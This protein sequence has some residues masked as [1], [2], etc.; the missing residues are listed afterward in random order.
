MKVT[1]AALTDIGRKREENQD[2]FLVDE[3]MGLFVVADGMGGHMGGEVASRTAV[4]LIDE[5]LHRLRDE[6]GFTRDDIAKRSKVQLAGERL[7]LSVR[8]AS[9][10]IFDLAQADPVN[11]REMGTTVVGAVLGEGKVAILHA[12][13]SRAYRV[14]GGEIQQLTDDHSMVAEQ[15]RAG[16]I[17]A[18]QAK[19]H[20]LKNW[21][22]RSVGYQDDVQLDTNLADVQPGDCLVLCSDGLTNHVEPPEIAAAVA[23]PP[24]VAVEKLVALANERGGEDNITVIVIRVEELEDKA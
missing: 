9:R 7:K 13:D 18:E 10:R 3:E 4:V 19:H 15:M 14:R 23:E 17:T 22:L 6:P 16:L 12:G 24:E 1:S 11:L 8:L 5:I 20:R 21:I 2:A